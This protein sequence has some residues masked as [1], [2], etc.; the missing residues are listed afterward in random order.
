MNK[1]IGELDVTMHESLLVQGVHGQEHLSPVK[2]HLILREK[3]CCLQHELHKVAIGKVLQQ[4]EV[5][6]EI[7]EISSYS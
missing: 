4:Q 6:L 2:L 7:L 1:K 5:L 3:T